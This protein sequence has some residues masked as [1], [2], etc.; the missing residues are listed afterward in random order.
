MTDLTQRTHRPMTLVSRTKLELNI[1]KALT[2]VYLRLEIRLPFPFVWSLSPS[3]SSIRLSLLTLSVDVAQL[4]PWKR[5]DSSALQSLSRNGNRKSSSTTTKPLE[6]INRQLASNGGFLS[7][8]SS[9]DNIGFQLLWSTEAS[10]RESVRYVR[11]FGRISD[12][13]L[14]LDLNYGG[15]M[16]ANVFGCEGLWEPLL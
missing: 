14:A 5:V 3:L 15:K 11:V 13:C 16:H 2:F 12:H 1:W 10:S 6:S 8:G 4:L 7:I 9:A